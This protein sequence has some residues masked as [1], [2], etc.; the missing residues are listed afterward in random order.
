MK[1]NTNASCYRLFRPDIVNNMNGML[2]KLALSGTCI[3]IVLT[4]VIM[5]IGLLKT[6]KQKLSVSKK[7]FLALSI[8]DLLTGLITTPIQLTMVILKSEAS[9]WLIAV[10]AFFNSFLPSTDMLLIL[11]ISLTRYAL[12]TKSKF[13]EKYTTPPRLKIILLL[14][15]ISTSGVSLWY[16]Y[17]S[18]TLDIYQ[19]GCFLIFIAV[20]VTVTMTTTF[21]V[22]IRLLCFVKKTSKCTRLKNALQYHKQVATTIFIIS[23]VLI[24]C[25]LPT[26]IIFYKIGYNILQE[27][28]L[29]QLVYYNYM[30]PW[31]HLAILLN[32]AL[33]SV[34]YISRSRPIKCYYASALSRKLETTNTELI[35]S[36]D[37]F[38]S[39]RSKS[40]SSNHKIT[41]KTEF[42]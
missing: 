30:V 22:N 34:V 14:I 9:C 5:I 24:I 11:N 28:N 2:L 20:F 12:V 38:K 21:A 7:L 16:V 1:N 17:V 39:T 8:A 19:H 33:N 29:Q 35:S 6:N 4:N 25:Y 41:E 13:F 40:R 10:Q 36:Q 31:A 27:T 32:S 37:A 42:L 3:F 15:V 23:I 18:Q 26:I